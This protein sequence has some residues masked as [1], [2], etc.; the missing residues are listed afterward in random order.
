VA[1]GGPGHA[2]GTDTDRSPGEGPGRGGRVRLAERP[3]SSRALY[4]EALAIER[5][6]GDPARLAEAVLNQAFAVAAEHDLESA[7]GLLDESLALFRQVGDEPGVA[8]VL[9][10][11]V[12]PDA[13]TGAW[14]RVIA[15][16]EEGVAI[17]RRLG[18]RLN[19]AFGLIWLG[20]AYGR[21]GRPEEARSTALGALELFREVDNATGIALAFLDL[22]FLLTWE[23]RHEDAIRMAGVSESQRDRAG[24]SPTPGFGSMLDGDPVAEASAHLTE[25]AARRAW[26][27]GLTMTV[28]EAVL[29]A[30]GDAVA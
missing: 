10:M 13:M 11:L 9:A 6:L 15:R 22:A 21:A 18:D 30:Q 23:G 1:R 3:G 8:R 29:L 26:Q 25:D 27:E 14:D 24:G 12:V 7:A 20:F 16:M 5:E 2:V 19:L 17:W 28:H 4:D